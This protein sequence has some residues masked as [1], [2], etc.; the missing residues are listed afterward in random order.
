MP[1]M[2]ELVQSARDE[3][4]VMA[5]VITRQASPLLNDI[6]RALERGVKVTLVLNVIP[7]QPIE[8]AA[9]LGR[10]SATFPHAIIRYFNEADGS[11]LHAKVLVADRDTAVVGSAN[12]TWGGLVAN[13][14]IG[15]VCSGRPAWEL[16]LLTDKLAHV[17]V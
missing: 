7:G 6:E 1:V 10:L 17:D 13:H 8:L 16:A 5:Y 9:E 15:V 2:Q 4:H 12:Y 14:E 11:Q 3:V